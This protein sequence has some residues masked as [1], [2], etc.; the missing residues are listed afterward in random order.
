M[1]ELQRML[2]G[3]T[4]TEGIGNK[5]Q[6]P[7]APAWNFVAPLASHSGSILA[8]DLINVGSRFQGCPFA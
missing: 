1:K 3:S 6:G 4:I 8:L 7:F 5:Q 2:L